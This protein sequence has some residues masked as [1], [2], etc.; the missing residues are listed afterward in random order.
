MRSNRN[1]EGNRSSFFICGAMVESKHEFC[2]SWK[3][4]FWFAKLLAVDWSAEHGNVL[5]LLDLE[6]LSSR[7]FAAPWRFHDF[8][9]QNMF[10]LWCHL[11]LFC[12]SSRVVS[13]DNSKAKELEGSLHGNGSIASMWMYFH[14][15]LSLF[16]SSVFVSK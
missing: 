6:K 1:P 5:L 2:I 3:I 14:K 15:K 11:P 10:K 13:R 12:Q 16:V 8:D 9:C 4:S 7:D